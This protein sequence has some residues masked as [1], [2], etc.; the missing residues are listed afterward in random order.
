M[1]IA[2]HIANIEYADV[3]KMSTS[4][5]E[6]LVKRGASALNPR[7]SRLS[8]HV[9]KKDIS[10]QAYESV[11]KSGGRFG[12]SK[13]KYGLDLNK[14]G[15]KQKYRSRLVKELFREKEFASFKTSTIREARQYYK[16][17]ISLLEEELSKKGVDINDISKDKIDYLISESWERFHKLQETHEY[18]PSDKLLVWYKEA[19]DRDLSSSDMDE[20]LKKSYYDD[21]KREQEEAL[22]GTENEEF[23][24]AFNIQIR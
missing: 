10:L 20:Y 1:T 12:V 6:Q 18:I 7:I 4:D 3:R 13:E 11:M 15:D 5:I 23:S 21:L 9:S 19:K 8:K 22:R 24:E 2:E 17:Q 16:E 14:N